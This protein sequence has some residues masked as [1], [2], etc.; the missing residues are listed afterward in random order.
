MWVRWSGTGVRKLEA[1][2]RKLEA[3]GLRPEAEVLRLET[4]LALDAASRGPANFAIP[5]PT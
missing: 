5:K 1:G 2:G 3:G 4:E